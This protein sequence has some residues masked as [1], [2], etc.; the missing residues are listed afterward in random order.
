VPIV[1]AGLGA[2]ALLFYDLFVPLLQTPTEIVFHWGVLATVWGFGFGLRRHELRAEASVRRAVEAEVAAAE[3][4]MAAVLAERTRIARELH[5]IVAHSVSTMVVQAGAAEQV[6]DEDPE[7]VR[8]ALAT[9]RT[10]GADALAEMRRVV[11]MLREDGPGELVP[12]PGLDGVAGLVA[13]AREEGLA[14]ILD[15]RG[16]R[17]ALPPGV[18]LTAY[19]VVQEAL[20][21]ARRHARATTVRVLVQ[22]LPEALLVEVADD[23]DGSAATTRSG[24]ARPP[25]AGEG[26]GHGLV[27]MRERVALYGG[28]VSASRGADGGFVVRATLPVPT[29]QGSPAPAASPRVP[30]LVAENLPGAPA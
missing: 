14:V 20:T 27:G 22:H 21:N 19:R 11:A 17:P 9:I 2:A 30:G 18:E 3:Q 26:G 16:T 25:V 15:E 12:Q 13:T 6:V 5:D 8:R 10:T 23:G 29:A 4:A 7:L 24:T 1:G 28:E